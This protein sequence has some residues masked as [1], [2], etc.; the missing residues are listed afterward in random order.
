MLEHCQ[1]E[2]GKNPGTQLAVL[3]CVRNQGQLRH[4]REKWAGPVLHLHLT[5]PPEVL[6]ERYLGRG[7]G[8]PMGEAQGHPAERGIAQLG[9][10]APLTIGTS[11]VKPDQAARAALAVMETLRIRDRAGV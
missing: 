4:I 7:D 8:L 10:S 1:D 3:D 9:R 6:A 5:A 2:L 11:W